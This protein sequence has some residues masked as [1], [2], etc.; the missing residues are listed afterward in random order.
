MNDP[1]FPIIK[2]RHPIPAP[3]IS[4]LLPA[5]PTI[6]HLIDFNTLP[7]LSDHDMPVVLGKCASIITE[8]HAFILRTL[9]VPPLPQLRQLLQEI[10]SHSEWTSFT[11]PL[12]ASS[13]SNQPS[14]TL[15]CWVMVWWCHIHSIILSKTA[16]TN[17]VQFIEQQMDLIEST[18]LV[19][20]THVLHWFTSMPVYLGDSRHTLTD[21]AGFCGTKWL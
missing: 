14:L 1:N 6:K 4:L 21:L 18:H 19:Q 9:L 11:Y 10:K 17:G 20:R 5:G 3:F 7:P 2:K 12:P 8:M 13:Q 16:W 15:P